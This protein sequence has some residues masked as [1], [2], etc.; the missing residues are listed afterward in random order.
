MFLVA[1]F[2]AVL[3]D[4]RTSR[5]EPIFPIGST[6]PFDPV[7]SNR[8]SLKVAVA[9]PI[10]FLEKL[11]Q[12]VPESGV[13][14]H[15]LYTIHILVSSFVQHPPY[16]VSLYEVSLDPCDCF[17]GFNTAVSIVSPLYLTL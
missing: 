4:G 5:G 17:L 1:I 13:H 15:I 10:A 11:E 14:S 16:T 6:L 8:I 12:R 2:D 3:P 7:T 9:V